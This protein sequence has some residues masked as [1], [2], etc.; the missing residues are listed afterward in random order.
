MA[1]DKVSDKDLQLII[2]S[3]Q[4][5]TIEHSLISRYIYA[6]SLQCL[7]TV[8]RRI[9]ITYWDNDIKLSICFDIQSWRVGTV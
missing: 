7:I 2:N 9:V 6:I 1:T 4:F 3:L 5:Y 8:I